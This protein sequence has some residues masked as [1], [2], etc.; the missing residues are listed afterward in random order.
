V[1][2][3]TVA[4]GWNPRVAVARGNADFP[5]VPFYTG[6][7]T[8]PERSSDHDMLVSYFTLPAPTADLR[9]TLAANPSTVAAG[10]SAS[11]TATVTNDGPFAAFNVVVTSGSMSQT[12]PVLAPGASQEVTFVQTVGTCATANGSQVT[13]TASVASDTADPDSGDNTA[14]ATVTVSNAAPVIAGVSASRTTLY[15]PLH[16]M[17]PVTVNYTASDSCGAVTTS[18]TVT[19]DEP[20]TAPVSQQGLSGL[21]SPDWQVVDD[22]HV[23]L[24]AERSIKGDGRVYTITVRATDAAGQTTTSAV[25]VTVPRHFP[26]LPRDID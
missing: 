12:I 7:A 10:G 4:Q 13:T 15:L 23:R 19:S 20:V 3:N 11:Y 21:T 25:T 16:I 6:D 22:H 2:I 9:L 1:L 26:G 18:L 8:R 14:S 5:E 24:R 17:V